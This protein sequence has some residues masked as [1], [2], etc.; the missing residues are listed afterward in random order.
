MKYSSDKT[1]RIEIN[2]Y[3]SRCCCLV[4]D[5]GLAFAAAHNNFLMQTAEQRRCGSSNVYMCARVL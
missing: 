5:D 3:H 2:I 1:L 4:A